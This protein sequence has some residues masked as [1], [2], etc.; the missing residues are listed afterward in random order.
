MNG[1][2]GGHENLGRIGV[3][4]SQVSESRPG[5]PLFVLL[6]QSALDFGLF[7]PEGPGSFEHAG[8]ME[9]RFAHAAGRNA[10][11]LFVFSWPEA[12]WLGRLLNVM[13]PPVQGGA[14]QF[15]VPRLASAYDVRERLSRSNPMANDTENRG[16][17]SANREGQSLKW[18]YKWSK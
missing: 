11:K 7:L 4:L 10:G 13:Q 16:S 1:G 5:A 17:S 9:V 18:S 14:S 15:E 3:V 12:Y 8:K 2:T 6:D